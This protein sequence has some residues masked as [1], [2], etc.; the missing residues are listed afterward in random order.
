MEYARMKFDKP[1]GM[2]RR[3]VKA[4]YKANPD[5][6]P[7]HLRGR[8]FGNEPDDINICH[9]IAESL[10]GQN[11]PLNFCLCTRRINEQFG[12][13]YCK[14]WQDYI[15]PQASQTAR[16]FAKYVSKKTTAVIHFGNFDP[17]SDAFLVK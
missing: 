15:G 10:G 2:P 6:I 13:Y 7:R 9:I 5:Q 4:W 8:E 16:A 11:W 3:A 12:I 14:E 1:G 17:V